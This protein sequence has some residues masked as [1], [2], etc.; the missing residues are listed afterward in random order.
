MEV[1]HKTDQAQEFLT[2]L[3]G[4]VRRA[5]IESSGGELSVECRDRFT[6][7]Q[8]ETGSL[9]ARVEDAPKRTKPSRW[10]RMPWYRI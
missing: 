5:V 6:R 1:T 3:L 2:S 7:F 10:D 9:I 4:T 8:V